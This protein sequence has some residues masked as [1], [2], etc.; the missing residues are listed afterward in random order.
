VLDAQYFL[1]A[2]G[3]PFIMYTLLQVY[4]QTHLIY[5]KRRRAGASL[6]LKIIYH[7]VGVSY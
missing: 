1:F 4:Q 5:V 3:L 6:S 7:L 2:I